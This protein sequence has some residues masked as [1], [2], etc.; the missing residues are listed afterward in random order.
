[1]SPSIAQQ[2]YEDIKY[3]YVAFVVKQTDG[4]MWYYYPQ[5]E[6]KKL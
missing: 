5:V 4:K 1:M 2:N 3:D 6:A